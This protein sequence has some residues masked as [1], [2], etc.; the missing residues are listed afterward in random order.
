MNGIIIRENEPFE[1]SMRRFT[2]LCE[3]GGVLSELKKYR[4]YEK[5]SEERKR[6]R[7]AAQQRL[8]RE[9][10]ATS[11]ELRNRKKKRKY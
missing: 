2:R 9:K 7:N 11:Y 3:H 6:K 10:T 4:H 8:L 1:K 5:P